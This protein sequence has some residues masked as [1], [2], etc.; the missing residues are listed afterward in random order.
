[1]TE[2]SP[3]TPKPRR[4]RS[5]GWTLPRQKRFTKALAI[6]G[7]VLIAAASVGL[8]PSSAYRFRRHRDAGAFRA[9][10]DAALRASHLARLEASIATL[11]TVVGDRRLMSL[12]RD[13]DRGAVAATTAPRGDGAKRESRLDFV[14]TYPSH[15]AESKALF[16]T[17]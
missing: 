10:W 6:S 3:T 13:G 5:D 16:D 2:P 12:L 17:A 7:S 4:I 8:S 15:H 1:M 11:A 14:P 9:A